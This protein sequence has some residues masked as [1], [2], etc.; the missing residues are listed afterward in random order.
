MFQGAF[1]CILLLVFVEHGLCTLLH[2]HFPVKF[3]VATRE[4]LQPGSK[5]C[6]T[7]YFVLV[8]YIKNAYW[9]N[10]TELFWLTCVVKTLICLIWFRGTTVKSSL[11]VDEKFARLPCSR[12]HL[13]CWVTYLLNTIAVTVQDTSR[14]CVS[15]Y[16]CAVLQRVHLYQMGWAAYVLWSRE[17]VGATR[18]SS[19]LDLFCCGLHIFSRTGWT[20]AT[21]ESLLFYAAFNV[22]IVMCM[23]T[24]E[25]DFNI[26]QVTSAT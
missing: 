8:F 25:N 18:V 7:H 15:G 24:L 11:V 12:L 13:F 17:L 21:I 23:D 26:M 10:K 19:S 3:F 16:F 2:S 22:D 5:H 1:T 14:L 20:I 6:L 9:W 4:L